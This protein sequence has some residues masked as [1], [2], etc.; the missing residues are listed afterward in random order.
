ML[1]SN[2]SQIVVRVYLDMLISNLSQL[3]VVRVYIDMREYMV[4]TL[5]LLH[6]SHLLALSQKKDL[7][8]LVKVKHL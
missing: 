3:V 6:N 5:K 1:I 8:D 4:D 7:I 2:L